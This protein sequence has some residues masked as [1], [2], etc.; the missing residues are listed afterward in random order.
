M[1]T[2]TPIPDIREQLLGAAERVLLRDGPDALIS[3]AV[4]TEAGVAKGILHRHFVDLNTFLATLVLTRIERL[5]EISAELRASARTATLPENLTRALVSALDPIAI[6]IV[7]LVCSRRE[8]LDKLRL[9]T[10]TGVP[11]L[12][13]TT[14]FIATYLTAE[15]G[16]GR[17]PITTDV[18]TLAIVLVG[19]AHLIAAGPGRATD[20]EFTSTVHAVIEAVTTQSTARTELKAP[21][22]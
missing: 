6:E 4:T 9:A 1:P 15:R 21:A 13:E 22:S 19:S 12:T 11:L 16:L 2:G 5:D 10:P 20:N 8:L 3:R 14:K 18:D 7:A 17:I